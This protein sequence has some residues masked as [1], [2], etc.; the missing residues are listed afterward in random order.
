MK[1]RQF[2]SLGLQSVSLLST[3]TLAPSLSVMAGTSLTT[4]QLGTLVSFID[5]LIPPD[6]TPSSSQLGLDKVL[7]NHAQTIQNYTALLILGCQWLDT[8]A[9]AMANMAFHQLQEE[10]R[11]RIVSLSET[12]QSGTIAR[13]FFDHVKADL[14]SFYYA[15]PA[16]WPSLGLHGAPQPHGYLS[17]ASQPRKL[18]K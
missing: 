3:L 8:Q 5:T 12:S 6:E 4:S 16:I 15:H 18:T 10:Q 14:F 2:L 17:Y 11:V 7:L 1:R 9:I 13:Q